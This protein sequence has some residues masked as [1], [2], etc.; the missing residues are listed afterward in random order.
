MQYPFTRC[1]V[2]Q[3]TGTDSLHQT[4]A[5]QQQFNRNGQ[6]VSETTYWGSTRWASERSYYKAAVLTKQIMWLPQLDNE[7]LKTTFAYNTQGQLMREVRFSYEKRRKKGLNKGHGSTGGDVLVKRDFQRRRTKE[8]TSE[9]S[10]SYNDC[11]QLV[12]YDAPQRHYSTQNRYTWTYD[13]LGRVDRYTSFDQQQLIWGEHYHY[14]TDGYQYTQTW[15]A[16]DGLPAHLKPEQKGYQPQYTFTT[17]L[18]KQKRVVKAVTTNEKAELVSS[19][20]K[21]YYLDG[22]LKKAVTLNKQGQ[23]ETTL[24]YYYY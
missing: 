22:K 1:Q 11:G 2:F 10:Y 14:F 24:L 7:K 3:F 23:P 8:K 13:S 17:Y 21:T 18:D 20:V 19:Q 9:I 5:L 6:L 15:F 16:Y 4:L 12:L